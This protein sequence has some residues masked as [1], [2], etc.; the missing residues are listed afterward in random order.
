[1][2]VPY[3]GELPEKT[4]FKTFRDYLVAQPDRKR[5]DIIGKANA[6]NPVLYRRGLEK[7]GLDPDNPGV[8]RRI[9]AEIILQKNLENGG[10]GGIFNTMDRHSLAEP[11][12]DA[13]PMDDWK[14]EPLGVESVRSAMT[15]IVFENDI[16]KILE[17]AMQNDGQRVIFK[18]KAAIANLGA[19]VEANPERLAAT[20][21]QYETAIKECMTHEIGV[22]VR[23]DGEVVA[24][25]RGV[26]NEVDVPSEWLKGCTVTHNHP[27]SSFLSVG[28][29]ALIIKGDGF[30][31][32]SVTRNNGALGFAKD[33]GKIQK[34]AE[35]IEKMNA[36]F[37]GGGPLA[38]INTVAEWAGRNKVKGDGSNKLR[39]FVRAW[40]GENAPN[41]GYT[42]K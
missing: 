39:E 12:L 20:L 30:E 11:P 27:N 19:R 25:V 15:P 6:A 5:A 13:P 2:L 14:L 7:R 41:Y 29:V 24:V 42:L 38:F 21:R 17:N 36:D 8:T 33:L 3:V 9:P 32:R 23:V 26:K 16:E 37:G 1:M 4:T 28:D 40:L 31:V 22:V 18:N 34:S 35:L 10:E